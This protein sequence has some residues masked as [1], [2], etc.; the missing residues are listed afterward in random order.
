MNINELFDNNYQIPDQVQDI[1]STMVKPCLWLAK[2][3]AFMTMFKN[4]ANM[5]TLCDKN[6]TQIYPRTFIKE[7]RTHK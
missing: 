1:S 4:I 2:S 3:S 6:T 7:K 5:T